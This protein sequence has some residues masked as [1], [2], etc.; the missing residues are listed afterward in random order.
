M[1]CL[2][3]NEQSGYFILSKFSL[4]VCESVFLSV[5]VLSIICSVSAAV[6][7]EVNNKYVTSGAQCRQLFCVHRPSVYFTAGR[8]LHQSPSV[9]I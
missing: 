3:I 6:F 5:C 8:L 7:C 2:K 1:F 4:S 9:H